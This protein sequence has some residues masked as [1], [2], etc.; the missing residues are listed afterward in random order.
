MRYAPA[1]ESFNRVGGAPFGPGR[2]VLFLDQIKAS[3]PIRYAFLLG[4]FENE[5]ETP[6]YFVASEV[7]TMAATLGGGSHFLGVFDG[8]GHA[9]RGASDD[10]ADPEKFFPEALRIAA[11]HF[12]ITPG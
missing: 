9:N 7:N 12:G 3:G 5:T 8:T 1:V 6:L 2:T 11:E 4:V 10:W